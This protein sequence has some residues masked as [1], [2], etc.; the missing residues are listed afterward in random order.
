MLSPT[1]R[2]V[3]EALAAA[4]AGEGPSPSADPTVEELEALVR[5]LAD[6]ASAAKSGPPTAAMPGD[7]ALVPKP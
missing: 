2:E 1:L 6:E 5:A 7:S 4:R 3:R